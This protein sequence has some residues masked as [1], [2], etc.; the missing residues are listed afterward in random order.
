M[1][2]QNV[3][4]DFKASFE[5]QNK[6]LKISMLITV[7]LLIACLFLINANKTLFL[8]TNSEYLTK[9]LPMKDVCYFSIKT[10]VEKKLSTSFISNPVKAY[11]KENKK[12]SINATKIYEPIV[13]GDNKCKVII[14]DHDKLRAFILSLEKS[15]SNPFIFKTIDVNEVVVDEKEVK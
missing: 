6:I 1:K 8:K 14:N 9:E 3:F 7:G 13:I 11:F 4:E 2:T 5:K 10:I 15:N 12:A